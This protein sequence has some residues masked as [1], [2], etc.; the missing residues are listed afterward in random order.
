[1][2]LK[3]LIVR[4]RGD[5]K[6]LKTS[7]NDS[8]KSV[9]KFNSVVKK[10]GATILGVFAIRQ[11][12]RFGKELVNIAA[13][14]EGIKKGFDKLN[15]PMLL[16]NLRDSTHETVSN[17]DLMQKAVQAKNFG[18]PVENLGKLFEFATARAVQ[19]GEAVDYLTNSIVLGIGRKSPLILDNLGISAVRLREALDNAGHSGSTVGEVAQAVGKIAALEMEKMGGF[20]DT[21]ATR[22]SRVNARWENMK[23]RIGEAIVESGLFEKAMM[24]LEAVSEWVLGMIDPKAALS[25]KETKE[26]QEA[27]VDSKAEQL[28]LEKKLIEEK[29]K[30]FAMD[31]NIATLGQKIVGI[32]KKKEEGEKTSLKDVKAQEKV[33]NQ[34]TKDLE[35]QIALQEALNSI[36]KLREPAPSPKPSREKFNY[37]KLGIKLPEQGDIKSFNYLDPD[38]LRKSKEALKEVTTALVDMDGIRQRMSEKGAIAIQQELMQID[39]WKNALQSAAMELSSLISG[40]L[41]TIFTA[42]G[43]GDFDNLFGDILSNFGK[44]ITQIGKLLIAY[45]AAMMAFSLLSKSPNP[46]S[47]GA[48]IAAGLAAVALGSAISGAASKGEQALTGGSTGGVSARASTQPQTL[49][50]YGKLRGSDIVII[51]DRANNNNST[52][53]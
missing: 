24:S 28:D 45:G 19:T 31:E 3:S 32:F 14:A 38:N 25:M 40:T 2:S 35:D 51:S 17:L 42:I 22:L 53:T 49:Q 46:I 15:D 33:I 26:L 39:E 13:K 20:I 21:T 30:Y 52:I 4:I 6:G 34:I 50:V 18:I 41:E 12:L 36:L 11:I 37:G 48:A 5:N 7:L 9:S 47:A 27:L 23:Q 8:G 44:F 29:A 10:L 43:A 1:M 16:K